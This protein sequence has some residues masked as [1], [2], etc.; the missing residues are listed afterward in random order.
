METPNSRLCTKDCRLRLCCLDWPTIEEPTREIITSASIEHG[1]TEPHGTFCAHSILP[2]MLE[3]HTA[4]KF[5]SGALRTHVAPMDRAYLACDSV[6]ARQSGTERTEGE[7]NR[8]EQE[9]IKL[10]SGRFAACVLYGCKQCANSTQKTPKPVSDRIGLVH[11][12]PR[13]FYAL[14]LSFPELPGIGI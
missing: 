1:S 9:Q 6:S 11:P 14:L 10:S 13:V 8:T 2:L 3:H 4:T 5:R 7:F 12:K